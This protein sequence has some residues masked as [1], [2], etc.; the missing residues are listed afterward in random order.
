HVSSESAAE[1]RRVVAEVAPDAIAIE[2]DEGRY[3]AMTDGKS[4]EKTDITQIIKQKKVGF[5]LA[6]ILLSSYQDRLAKQMEVRVGEEMRVAIELATTLHL[7]VE[8]IDRDIQTTFLRIWRTLR[9]KDKWNLLIALVSSVFEDEKISEQE[10]ENLKQGD[11]IQAMISEFAGKFPSI[12][13]TLVY[14]RDQ[15]MAYQLKHNQSKRIVAVVGAAHVAGILKNIQSDY[16]LAPL[17][18]LPPK[19]NTSKYASYLVPG[20]LILLLALTSLKVPSLAINTILRF[21]LV[22]GTFAALGTLV[23]FGHP[24]SILTAFVMA[25]VGALSPVLATGWFA[26]LMEAWVRK[27][28]VED[29]LRINI[30]ASSFKGFWKNRVLRILL[31]VI[32]AN[33]FA[34]IGTLV[35]S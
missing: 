13:E 26:G 31:V 33:L 12:V 5:L 21:I 16:E 30:D 14:E 32:L 2:L 23:A 7:K 17:L 18:V 22:N 3:K 4:W 27:P 29:F 15:V 20:I 9:L 10:I 8:C 25:P 24:F 11:L 34:T 35:I 28:K 6:N 19:S 1:V